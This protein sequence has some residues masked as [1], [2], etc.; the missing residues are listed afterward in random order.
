MILEWLCTLGDKSF[1]RCRKV[2]IFCLFT[3]HVQLTSQL[4]RQISS[5]Q[6]PFQEMFSNVSRPFSLPAKLPIP[7]K[8]AS[9]G[10]SV[11][12]CLPQVEPKGLCLEI[13]S[14]L[15]SSINR[16]CFSLTLTCNAFLFLSVCFTVLGVCVYVCVCSC[17]GH[18]LSTG[19]TAAI[20]KLSDCVS[21]HPLYWVCEA[22]R[23]DNTK[24]SSCV[25]PGC[26]SVKSSDFSEATH[27]CAVCCHLSGQLSQGIQGAIAV[28]PSMTCL[29]ISTAVAS[30]W[31]RYLTW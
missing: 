11:S 30:L 8:N 2:T 5:R 31:W 19:C 26:H 21:H 13:I 24:V 10:S 20:M 9:W 6:W 25:W 16:D 17:Y 7:K 28:C 29:G 14:P 23:H 15:M 27:E 4:A 22:V 3:G 18:S 12:R 1:P